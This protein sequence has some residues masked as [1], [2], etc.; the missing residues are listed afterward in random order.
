[1][2]I[3]EFKII[4][5]NT[6]V[7]LKIIAKNKKFFLILFL[8]IFFFILIFDSAEYVTCTHIIP[9]EIL[10]ILYSISNQNKLIEESIKKVDKTKVIN[11][12][13]YKKKAKIFIFCPYFLN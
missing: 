10:D 8:F 11:F 9:D 6:K 4:E 1:M 7:K 3:R 2:F 5:K 13:H 12:L